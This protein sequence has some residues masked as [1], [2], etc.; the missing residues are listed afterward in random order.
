MSSPPSASRWQ[1]R[2]ISA[3]AGTQPDRSLVCRETQARIA[4][5]RLARTAGAPVFA[6]QSHDAQT[7]SFVAWP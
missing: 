5:R 3:R 4:A 1:L 2:P 7:C 6:Y